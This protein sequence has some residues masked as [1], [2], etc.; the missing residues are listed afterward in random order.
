MKMITASDGDRFLRDGFLMVRGLFA[1]GEI[2]ALRSAVNRAS[3]A[4]HM[5]GGAR[6]LL[7]TLLEVH[8]IAHG[9]AL[10]SVIA[11]LLKGRPFPVHATL[12]DKTPGANW[13]VPWHQDLT[14]SVVERR[15][16]E[17]YG[18][19]SIKAGVIH[20]Q[21]PVRIMEG[22]I[23]ARLHLDACDA[24]NGVLRVLPGTHRFGRL[25]D[26]AVED[27]KR[28]IAPVACTAAAGDVLL[29]RPLLLHA[30]SAATNPAHRRVIH[31]DYACTPLDG[32]IEWRHAVQ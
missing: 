22:M 29:M 26:A 14:I 27:C 15:D 11:P 9:P 23:S 20:V 1:D 12:F 4:S 7:G 13:L 6:N 32:G 5:R 19:W 3:S 31:I 18:P 2:N 8:Q 28:S 10:S 17:G 30:S 16:V 25:D 21:P 24:D